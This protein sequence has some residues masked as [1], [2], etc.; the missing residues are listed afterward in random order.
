[1]DSQTLELSMF[2]YLV[3]LIVV[4]TECIVNNSLPTRCFAFPID[5][6]LQVMDRA[7]TIFKEM[8]IWVTRT[9]GSFV[10]ISFTNRLVGYSQLHRILYSFYQHHV[11]NLPRDL[12]NYSVK[13]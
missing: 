6:I 2:E 4:D 8:V 10:Q 12:Y 5:R 13:T 11:A 1:M 3:L 7:G 9:R